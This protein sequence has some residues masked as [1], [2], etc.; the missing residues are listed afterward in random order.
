[1]GLKLIFVVVSRAMLLQAVA[2][3]AVVEG[4]QDL[5]PRHQLAVAQRERPRRQAG[6]HDLSFFQRGGG[7]LDDV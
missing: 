6:G 1:V 4:S 2:P 3:G 5:M 7:L